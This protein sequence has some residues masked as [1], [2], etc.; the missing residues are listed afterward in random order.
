[1]FTD[2]F[3]CSSWLKVLTMSNFD[4]LPAHCQDYQSSCLSSVYL[5][6]W[7]FIDLSRSSNI[8]SCF[9]SFSKLTRVA[10][11]LMWSFTPLWICPESSKNVYWFSLF[12]KCL[13]IISFLHCEFVYMSRLTLNT[14]YLSGTSFPLTSSLE[15]NIIFFKSLFD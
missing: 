13:G 1:M 9:Y 2:L 4:V 6:K 7:N 3:P 5:R 11:M 10:F 14:E 12:W 15:N 8:V